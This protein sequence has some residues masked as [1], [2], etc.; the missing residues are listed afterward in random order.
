MYSNYQ[1][2]KNQVTHFAEENTI[3]HFFKID[4]R[5]F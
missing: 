2:D 3:N 5:T 1:Y 4:S